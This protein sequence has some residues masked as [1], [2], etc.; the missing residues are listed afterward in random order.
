MATPSREPPFTYPPNICDEIS[1]LLTL[2]F[3][4]GIFLLKSN[5][6]IT[7]KSSIKYLNIKFVI[8]N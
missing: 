5:L 2:N 1:H 8:Y 4:I 3:K 7:R 6:M